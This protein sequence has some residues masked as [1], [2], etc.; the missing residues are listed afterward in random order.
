MYHINSKM[1]NLL[2]MEESVQ[3]GITM[4]HDK[5]FKDIL[6]DKEEFYKFI[7]EFIKCNKDILK[8]IV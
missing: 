2:L 6:N 4:P 5:L 1:Y 7:N 8:I 3:Y